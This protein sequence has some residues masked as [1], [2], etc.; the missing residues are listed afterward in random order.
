MNDVYKMTFNDLSYAKEEYDSALEANL[1]VKN[2]QT[3]KELE[4]KEKQLLKIGRAY[5][6]IRGLRLPELLSKFVEENNIR[7]NV[8]VKKIK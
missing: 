7:N 6:E 1:R 8:K 2:L 5:Y 3:L 4:I